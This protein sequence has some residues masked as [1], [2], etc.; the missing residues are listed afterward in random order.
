MVLKFIQFQWTY[1]LWWCCGKY[2]NLLVNCWTRIT[3]QKPTEDTFAEII[4]QRLI[5]W[6]RNNEINRYNLWLRVIELATDLGYVKEE[7]NLPELETEDVLAKKNKEV[8]SES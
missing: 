6:N 5:W 2:G 8:S 1:F 7:E 3:P 4:S